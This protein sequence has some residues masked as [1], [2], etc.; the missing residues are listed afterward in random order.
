MF[1]CFLRDI[2]V[3]KKIISIYYEKQRGK[4]I[5]NFKYLDLAQKK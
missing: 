4:K 5:K 2:L 1:S 3:Y